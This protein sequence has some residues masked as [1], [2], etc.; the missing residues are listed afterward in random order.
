MGLIRRYAKPLFTIVP[1]IMW[2]YLAW[3][4]RYSMNPS[5]YPLQKRY[6]K[7]HRLVK[8][9][10]KSLNID[11]IVE[12]LEQLPLDQNLCFIGNHLGDYDGIALLGI[13]E[14]PLAL[15]GK[16]EILKYPLISTALKALGGDFIDRNDLKQSLKVMR[17]VQDSM[18]S[19]KKNWAIF[20]EGTR[21]KDDRRLVEE[22][23]HGTFRTPMKAKIAIC[24]FAIIGTNRVFKGSPN[25]KRYPIH[26]K[27]LKPLTYQDY[28]DKTTEQVAGYCQKMIQKAI[29]FDLRIK[30]HN[31][32]LA[33]EPKKYKLL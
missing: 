13:F 21:R 18:T 20:P 31:Y 2:A 8:K 32:M 1:Q 22:F 19:K 15:I 24:P 17:K 11:M 12:G 29:S 3:L 5:K 16:I 4:K 25:Y 27:F 14:Q 9:L 10:E 33:K 28:A 26:I 6:K 7:I 23:H 30:D